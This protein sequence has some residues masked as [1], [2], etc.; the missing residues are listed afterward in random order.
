VLDQ[1]CLHRAGRRRAQDLQACC[2]VGVGVIHERFLTVQLEDGG[3]EKDALRVSQALIQINDYSHGALSL[4]LSPKVDVR[5]DHGGV[6]KQV[7]L[8]LTGGT[9]HEPVEIVESHARPLIDR[10]ERL[11][12]TSILCGARGMLTRFAAQARDVTI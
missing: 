7:R 2:I 1:D 10:A 8:P 9:A 5:I 3:S 11:T 12:L 4:L 6:A